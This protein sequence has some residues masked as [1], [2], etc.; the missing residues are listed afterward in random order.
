MSDVLNTARSARSH[1]K[2]KLKEKKNEF[3]REKLIGNTASTSPRKQGRGNQYE[4][5]FI[6]QKLTE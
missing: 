4:N 6:V 3:D 2:E 1:Q 5:S